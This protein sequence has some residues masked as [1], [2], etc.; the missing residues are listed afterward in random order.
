MSK[1]YYQI[2]GVD[3]NATEAEIKKAFRKQAHK[4]H[5][6][7]PDGDE[8]KFKEVNEA[9]SVLSNP[10]K[11]KQY[12]T[13]GQAGPEMGGG[14]FAGGNPFAD[15]DFSQFNQGGSFGGF[16]FSDIFSGF[17]GEGFGGSRSRRGEDIH[18]KMEINFKDSV[19]GVEK[20]IYVKKN[21]ACE[22]CQGSGA[23]KNSNLKT[24]V[25]CAGKGVVEK[26]QQ[27]ILGSMR[28]RQECP[29]CQGRGEVPEK[30]CSACGGSGV[31]YRKTEIK[32]KIPAGVEDGN[33]LRISGAGE[34]VANGQAGDLYLHLD[35]KN[36]TIFT[37]DGY[38]LNRDLELK[39]TE[40]VLGTKKEVETI[41]GKVKI[42]IPAGISQGDILKVKNEGVVI[43]EGRRGNLFLKV[44]IKIPQKLSRAEKKL[45]EELKELGI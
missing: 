43:A 18:L 22:Q 13:F 37:K 36:N 6:D 29:D 24:C 25:T 20:N 16:D 11:R 1:D 9:Y 28:S 17:G 5:P 23:E 12:D 8:I 38:D 26:V 35:I 7:K 32:V 10:E 4:Y 19:F 15:F 45:F 41:D 30:K 14:G 27:T 3:K 31:E 2:L 42:K 44:K 40:A 39:L 33:Q 34:Y 21:S